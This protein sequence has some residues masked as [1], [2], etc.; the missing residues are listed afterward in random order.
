MHG[1]SYARRSSATK[2]WRTGTG[3]GSTPMVGSMRRITSSLV[4]LCLLLVPA[5]ARAEAPLTLHAPVPGAVLAGFRT[6]PHPWSAGHRG[7]DLAARAGEQVRAAADGVVHFAG[8]VAGRGSVSVDHGG[9]VR[10]TYTPVRASVAEGDRVQRGDVLATVVPGHCASTC[11]HWGLTDGDE[12]FDPLAHVEVRRVELIAAGSSPSAPPRLVAQPGVGTLP[13]AGRITSRFGMRTHPVTGVHKLHDGVDIAAPCG[14]P[15]HTAWTGRV[16]RVERHV[17][18][19]TRV[20][21]SHG[22]LRS[23]YAH[24]QDVQVSLGQEVMAGRQVGTVG[25]TGMSTGCHLHWMAWQ[26][27]ALTD[28]LTLMG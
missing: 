28:P 8:T 24:L 11:L 10:T 14:T 5:S 21:L 6:G 1:T 12:Y 2:L 16:V 18:Y 9:G 17:A 26:D 13:V 7:V 23:A 27:G 4:L 15:V 22:G 25:N 19:G 3:A 20:I